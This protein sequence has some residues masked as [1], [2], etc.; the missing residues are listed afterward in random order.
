[1]E[2]INLQLYSFGHDCGLSAVEKIKTAAGMGYAGV[3]F[4]QDYSGVPVEDIKKALSEAGIKAVSAHVPF[5]M[6]GEHLPYL[7][8]LGVKFVACPMTSFCDAEEAKEVAQELN[9]W[10]A[11][12]KK[13]GITIGYH[14]HTQE[15]NKDQDKYLMDWVIETT[16]PETVAFEI[17]CGWASHA[18]RIA[19]I[20]IK[21][22]G[23][24]IGPDKASSRKDPPEWPKFE[25]DEDGKPIFPP[26]FIKMMQERDKLNVP[27]GSGIVDWKA[28]KAA[29]D[30]QRD[31]VIYVVER[32]ASYDGKSRV[33]CLKED[34]AWLKAN[35]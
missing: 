1:M 2:N 30:A 9:K 3:E 10:G 11:E 29:A 14:N 28:I 24:V 22:N 27:T 12:A 19:A 6:M 13:Y 23:A 5:E 32:E 18:G 21:E 34:V 25:L 35:V 33:D 17:D 4:A 20:H 16:D 26:E 15:F 8:E 31:G 7:A